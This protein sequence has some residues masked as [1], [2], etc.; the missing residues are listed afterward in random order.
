MSAALLIAWL[1][2]LAC[3]CAVYCA[4]A[5]HRAR[6]ALA[7][8]LGY[9]LI[10]GPLLAGALT[11]LCARSDTA[12]A[13]GRAAPCLIALTLL[14]AGIA[15]WRRRRTGTV[16]VTAAPAEKVQ[17]WTNA[18]IAFGCAS[19]IWRGWLMLREIVLRPTYPWDAWDAWAV[20]SKTWFLLGHYVPFV[21]VRDWLLQQPPE[22]HTGPAWSYPAG[23]AWMQVWFAS[24]AGGWIEPLVNLPWF[25]LWVGL[26]A[27]HYG[28][29]RALGLTR[30]QALVFVY[31]LG[32]LPLLAVHVAL[33]GYADL[34]VAALL[35]LAVLSWLRW[36][37]QRDRSQLLLGVLC[38]LTLPLIKL[39]GVVWLLLFGALAA[40]SAMP[41]GRRK[42][43]AAGIVLVLVVMA[44]IGKLLLPLYGLGWVSFGTNIIDV[45]VLGKLPIGWHSAAFSAL[46]SSLFAQSNW[47]LLWWLAPFIVV[48]RWRE[49]RARDATRLLGLLLIAALAFLAF[50]FL[51]TDAARWAESFTAFNRLL[52]HIV[53]VTVTLCALLI[54]VPRPARRGRAS[55]FDPPRAPA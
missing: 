43:I 18:L 55:A 30:T 13:L 26:L 53:P 12:H 23:L 32:S 51:F 49:L 1:L 33:A 22:A 6:G 46:V 24:A 37:E 36:I 27:A 28:Q 11:A 16:R 48:W 9:G 41:R 5:A 25:A 21:S 45:P 52:M 4:I 17:K 2:A 15:W 38:A 47:H 40:Y 3:G 10:T 44:V 31:I 19:L 54:C 50:L 14:A 39:E 7:A 20:K 35:G 34:W 29:W 42:W 8:A